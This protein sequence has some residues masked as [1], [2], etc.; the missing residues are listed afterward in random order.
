MLVGY[1]NLRELERRFGHLNRSEVGESIIYRTRRGRELFRLEENG[2]RL[3]L[4]ISLE[5]L[6]SLFG[7]MPFEVE[8]YGDSCTVL[9]HSLDDQVLLWTLLEALGEQ[10]VDTNDEL[11]RADPVD[12]IER[13]MLKLGG[14][15]TPVTINRRPDVIPSEIAGSTRAL[16]VQFL[17]KAAVAGI[18]LLLTAFVS[19]S[20]ML[21][22]KS[23]VNDREISVEELL[24]K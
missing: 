2:S 5:I 6:Q 10:S 13:S 18:I 12:V 16:P 4:P 8:P 11:R 19:L 9:L 14:P 15:Q 21:G 17:V 22:S 3:R 20:Y 24:R 23:V 1:S 7:E